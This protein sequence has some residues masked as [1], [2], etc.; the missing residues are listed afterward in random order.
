MHHGSRIEGTRLALLAKVCTFRS[1]HALCFQY[2]RELS[3]LHPNLAA[4]KINPERSS[5]CTPIPRLSVNQPHPPEN[6]P[7]CFLPVPTPRLRICPSLQV[8]PPPRPSLPYPT[9]IKFP[10][11]HVLRVPSQV[12]LKRRPGRPPC[13]RAANSTPWTYDDVDSAMHVGV[14][15]FRVG[16]QIRGF[17]GPVRILPHDEGFVE[18]VEAVTA[19]RGGIDGEGFLVA[20]A[21][22]EVQG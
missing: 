10:A 1:L 21:V 8:Y 9:T 5:S 20:F 2:P 17:G 18:G 22:C 16:F 13:Y 11:F 6:P 4:S 3:L 19:E 15:G 14:L 7:L 12:P